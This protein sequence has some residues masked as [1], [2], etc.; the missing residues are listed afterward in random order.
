MIPKVSV[1]VPTYNRADRVCGTIES[2]LA[3][4]FSD[5]EVIVV[6]DGSTDR[7]AEVAREFGATVISSQPLP[8]GWRGK[9]WACHQGA[10]LAR[11]ELLLFV[12]ADTW[13]E[14]EGLGKILG[15]YEKGALSVGPY[16]VVPKPYEQLS[17][18]FNLVM[19]VATIPR[20]LFGQM[21]LVDR[22][23]YRRVG[24]HEAVKNR[25]LENVFLAERFVREGIAARSVAGQGM[26][27][28]RMYPNGLGPLV[29]GWTKGFASGA[30][31]TNGPT[32]LLIVVWLTG[33]ML[34]LN[35]LF[36]SIWAGPVY[37]IYVL[38]LAFALRRVGSFRWYTAL[39]YP[40]P[41]I[42]FFVVFAVSALRSGRQVQWKGRSFRAD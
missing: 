40:I 32:L 12:D 29:Q 8:E 5:F 14:E 6:D 35:S 15:Q 20:G 22:E 36:N 25:V 38:Q 31:R 4:S 23:S 10:N 30:G 26:F 39:L 2:V 21:L 11:G 19:T 24:G 41:L 42:F 37:L 16:H 7:T 28:F 34:P 1:V 17:A 3:Q 9:T 18:F 13:F 33:M 27:A